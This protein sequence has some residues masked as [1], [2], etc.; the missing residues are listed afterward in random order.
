M[1]RLGVGRG[2]RARL[3]ATTVLAVGAALAVLV[4]GFNL[5]LERRLDAQATDLARARAAATLPSVA[6]RGGHVEISE[7]PD[8]AAA[9]TQIWVFDGVHAVEA[10]RADAATASAAGGL[11]SA[12]TRSSLT[13]NGIRLVAVPVVAG[14]R[15]LGT[16]V[17][18]VSLAPYRQAGDVALA[19]SLVLA[20]LVLAAVTLITRT[21]L[22]RA[23]RPVAAMT[24]TATEWSEHAVDRRFDLGD[25][26]DELTQLAATL[27]R[28]LDRIAETLRREQRLTAEIS[29][30]LRTPLARIATEAELA[31]RRRRS[32]AEYE[33][34]LHAIA[35]NA[36]QLR[37]IIEALLETARTEAG[38]HRGVAEAQAVVERS[39]E[40]SMHIAA[41]RGIE[42]TVER[43]GPGVR[44]AVAVDE[45]VASRVLQPVL[46]NACRYGRSRVTVSVTGTPRSVTYLVHDDGPG[47]GAAEREAIFDPGR[48]GGGAD[49]NPDGV[50]LGLALSR[51]LARAAGG[52]VE[53]LPSREGGVFAVRLP[54]AG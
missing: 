25:P 36:D 43:P 14:G 35:R 9:G 24:S 22:A 48:R 46:E 21:I 32:P 26:H 12:P 39:L 2:V 13:V 1:T 28:L 54:A 29:H 17:G 20:I 49:G 40:G 7:S 4:V 44:L 27:D 41:E 50:G 3:L 37:R 15:R 52:E 19:G 11:A 10:P 18:G 34:A 51:R 8:A 47:V 5:L 42:V 45:D 53:A 33:R 23:L 30:E 31:V 16:V 38:T 6:V